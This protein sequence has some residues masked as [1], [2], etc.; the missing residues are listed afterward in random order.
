MG[1]ALR[2]WLPRM[3][4]LIKPW[5]SAEEIGACSLWFQETAK[6]L[7][8]SQF[9]I[10]CLTSD[11]LKEPWIQIDDSLWLGSE[12]YL[13]NISAS[14]DK[15]DR[16]ELVAYVDEA[17]QFVHENG[18]EK[19]LEAFNDPKGN[20]TRDGRYIFAYDYD[21]RTLALPYQPEL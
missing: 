18:K 1:E 4:Q 14:F 2:K 16:D 6:E 7:S 15:G 20:F 10:I 17:L 11:N 12:T 13:S 5:M 3:N 9:G 21:G 8:E 19:A